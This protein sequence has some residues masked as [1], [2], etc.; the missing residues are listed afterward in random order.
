MIDFS[1]IE[2]KNIMKII[3]K[4]NVKRMNA[5][6]EQMELKDTPIDEL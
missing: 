6:K 3:P 2:Q 4:R 1:E 5:L